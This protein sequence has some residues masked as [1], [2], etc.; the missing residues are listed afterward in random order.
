[1]IRLTYSYLY[2]FDV[3]K[4]RFSNSDIFVSVLKRWT[5]PHILLCNIGIIAIDALAFLKEGSFALDSQYK[6]ILIETALLALLM[7]VLLIYEF[8]H[9]KKFL[10]FE[11]DTME[12]ESGE[13]FSRLLREEESVDKQRRRDMLKRIM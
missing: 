11:Y 10:E 5:I 6:I 7:A 4:A 8:Y 12:S 13:G 9:L 1:M 3:F 2:G